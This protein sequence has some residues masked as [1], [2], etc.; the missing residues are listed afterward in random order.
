MPFPSGENRLGSQAGLVPNLL[1]GL[2]FLC[3]GG[4]CALDDSEAGEQSQLGLELTG[5]L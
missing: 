1:L 2:F 5:P 4:K 3:L